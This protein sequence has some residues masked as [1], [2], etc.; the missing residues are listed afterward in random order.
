VGSPGAAWTGLSGLS[1]LRAEGQGASPRYKLKSLSSPRAVSRFRAPGRD[2]VGRGPVW[3]R[4]VQTG[5][6]SDLTAW[7]AESRAIPSPWKAAG[8][9]SSIL[10]LGARA[11]RHSLYPGLGHDGWRM[12]RPHGRSI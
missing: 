9:E 2:T 10:G 8:S 3:K 4:R 7:A 1:R 6:S 11:Q 12:G 5:K